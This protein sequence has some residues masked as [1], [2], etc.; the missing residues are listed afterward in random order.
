MR[1]WW[2][3]SL[4]VLILIAISG[5]GVVHAQNCDAVV[6]DEANLVK[7]QSAVETAAQALG[8]RI[9]A[10]V[11]VRVFRN[12]RGQSTLP[13]FIQ[14]IRQQCSSWQNP[15][16]SDIRSNL[17]VIAVSLDP[18]RVGMVVGGDFAAIADQNHLRIEQD[19]MGPRLR[20]K[21]FDGAFTEALEEFGRVAYASLH[22]PV[23][24]PVQAAQPPAPAVIVHEQPT[25]FSGL[26]SAM[27]WL[28]FI[29]VLGGVVWLIFRM[30]GE[31]ERRRAAQQGAQTAKAKT[32]QLINDLPGQLEV[33]HAQL[34]AL[35][36]QTSPADIATALATLERAKRDLDSTT[37]AYSD[38]GNSVSDPDKPGLSVIEYARIEEEY[39]ALYKNLSG[40]RTSLTDIEKSLAEIQQSIQQAPDKVAAADV[41]RDL[42]GRR[43]AEVE[44]QG[45]K[46]AAAQ[47][48]LNETAASLSEQAHVALTSREYGKAISIAQKAGDAAREAAKV[49]ENL[50]GLRKQL[51]ERLA[52]LTASAGVAKQAIVDGKTT[53]D[54]ISASYAKTTW[55]SVVGNGTEA[56][57]RL[58]FAAQSTVAAVTAIGMEVQDWDAG[59]KALDAAEQAVAEAMS[60]MR[61]VQELAKSLDKAK[62]H[63]QSDLEAAQADVDRSEKYNTEVDSDVNDSVW[64]KI[65]QAKKLLEGATAELARPQP[66]YFVVLEASKKAHAIADETLAQARS[67][68]EAADRLRKRAADAVR[69]ATSRV[70]KATEYI[71]DHRSDVSRTAKDKLKDAQALLAQAAA[72]D[73]V[74]QKVALAEQAESKA[75]SAYNK[76]KD[77]F[78]AAEEERRPRYTTPSYHDTT[79][80]VNAPSYGNWGSSYSSPSRQDD[81]PSSSGGGDSSFGGGFSGGGDSDFGGGGSVSGGGDSGW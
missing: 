43:I 24:P 48:I 70:S 8:S 51:Q 38:F 17:F 57:K 3:R 79:V 5:S 65:K 14:S 9:G 36:T 22:P 76:A 44:K 53:F 64:P 80:I 37:L 15:S 81:T 78:E 50:L 40:T 61:S 67:E 47:K 11:R 10:D 7:N 19:L 63:A 46:V 29:F 74:Q 69:D 77:D 27:K 12:M 25:D 75:K 41:A 30:K 52:A 6:V 39:G 33:L 72:S 49:A 21:D 2:R 16:N 58:T 56:T 31:V 71:E 23:A 34:A 13:P 55:S 35:K 68:H 60:L 26:W 1:Y 54:R 32:A 73:D 62:A 20:R 18:R 4:M 45:F 42:A 28:L 59:M 66:D